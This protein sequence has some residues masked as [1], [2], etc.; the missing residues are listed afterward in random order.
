MSLRDKLIFFGII[1]ALFGITMFVYIFPAEK[2]LKSDD[3]VF[4]TLKSPQAACT[5]LKNFINL[6]KFSEEKDYGSAEKYFE[7][8]KC[9]R[10]NA[11]TEVRLISNDQHPDIL[12]VKP[13]DRSIHLYISSAISG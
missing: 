4:V 12:V 1:V 11:G 3:P 10:L 2:K 6:K 8:G 13:V 5:T 9:E 7:T